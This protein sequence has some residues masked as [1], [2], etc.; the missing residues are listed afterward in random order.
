MF[1]K[2]CGSHEL[3]LFRDGVIYKMFGCDQLIGKQDIN[4]TDVLAN[5]F[6]AI[7]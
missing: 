3:M 5:P 6:L 7:W 2:D 4:L 1:Q